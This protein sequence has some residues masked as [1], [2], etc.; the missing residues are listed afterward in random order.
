M[1]SSVLSLALAI[2]IVLAVVWIALWAIKQFV[3][4]PA[5]IEKGV[6]IIAMLICLIKLALWAGV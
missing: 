1:I 5:Q 6:W 3:A 4:I 2:V